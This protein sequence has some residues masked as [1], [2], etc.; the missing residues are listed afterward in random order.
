MLGTRELPHWII[1]NPNSKTI[2]ISSYPSRIGRRGANFAERNVEGLALC[3]KLRR[4]ATLSVSSMVGKCFMFCVLLEMDV[5]RSLESA[6]LTASC[7]EKHCL[8]GV[9]PK[10][11]RC[12]SAQK[13]IILCII[14]QIRNLLELSFPPNV[15]F[16]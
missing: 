3:Q 15:R 2:A 5:I 10:N 13:A 1:S 9:E 8:K 6:T 11:S 16:C 4:L 7:T 12:D 14:I